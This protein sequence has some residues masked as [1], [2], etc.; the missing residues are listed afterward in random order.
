MSATVPTLRV[1]KRCLALSMTAALALSLISCAGQTP[2]VSALKAEPPKEEGCRTQLK[3]EI[4]TVNISIGA[5]GSELSDMINRLVGKEFYKGSTGTSGVNAK[6]LRNGPIVLKTADNALFLAIP[7]S[8][9][10]SYG[11]FEIPAVKAT[12]KFKLVPKVTADWKVNV[13][14]YYTGLAEALADD[15]RVGPI[16]IKPRGIVEGITNPLQRTL[17]GLIGNKLNEKFPLRVQVAQAWSAA[18]KAILLDKNYH[19]WLKITPRELLLYPLYAKDNQLRL[20]VGL[21]SYAEVVVGPEPAPQ[22]VTPLPNLTLAGGS[23]NRFRVALNTD[24]FYRDLLTI[25]SPLLLNKE[26][27]SDGKSIIVTGIDLYGNG[28]R[29]VVKLDTTGSLD[30]T[31]Y[32]AGRPVFDPRTNRFSMQDLDFDLQSKSLLMASADWFLHGVIKNTIQEKLNLDLTPQLTQARELAGKAMAR[33][34]LADNI[35]LTGSVKALTV[36]DV[37]VQKDKISVQVYTEGE[38]AILFH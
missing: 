18:H 8:M 22:P 34:N 26:L 9:S 12:L 7:I 19:A 29:L 14:V 23:D 37:M 32:L 27:G 28:E 6:V 10:V 20:S 5:S 38:S 36:N 11:I 16:S 31:F 33:V 30:G 4:S 35:Y 2:R 21:R 13:E 3:Q 24:L 25:A 17:S 15:L 1:V